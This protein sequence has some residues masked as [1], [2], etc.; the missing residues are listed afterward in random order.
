MTQPTDQGALLGEAKQALESL[1]RA[2]EERSRLDM[3]AKQL[4][5]QLDAEKKAAEDAAA[6]TVKKRREEINASYDKE[7][8]KGQ[9]RLRRARQKREK[10]KNQ[11]MRGRIAEETAELRGENRELHLKLKGL[12]QKEG[13]P[14]F[15]GSFWYYALYIPRTFREIGGLILAVLFFFAAL[16]GG[17]YLLIQ[18]SVRSSWMLIVIYLL[19]IFIV[20]GIYLGVSNRTKAGHLEIIRQGRLIRDTIRGNEKKIR[21]ITSTI[22]RDRNESLYNLEK[23]D[24]EIAK[25][26]QELAEITGKK[27]EALTAFDTV[28]R[29]IISDE[30]WN[31]SK[32][33]IDSLTE[34]L[35]RRENRQRTLEKQIQEMSLEITDRYE[36]YIGKEFMQPDK[37]AE[38]ARLIR[39]GQAANIS[40]AIQQYK[41]EKNKPKEG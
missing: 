7:I 30:I 32:E 15:C 13:L 2:K 33:K 23:Y 20:G 39:S 22:R 5:K 25:T 36:T 40:D 8:A 17:I 26:E 41:E 3:E 24:D 4:R 34:D 10:A 28:T 38:L 37:L 16:P 9:D 14:G 35:E 21:V 11:R 29:T 1:N 19:D 31:N 18:E 12:L 6:L 27:Q